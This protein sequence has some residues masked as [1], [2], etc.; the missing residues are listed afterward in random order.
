M[1]P[2]FVRF[3]KLQIRLLIPSRLLMVEPVER[4]LLF[5]LL[6][7]SGS[8]LLYAEDSYGHKM[9]IYD[10]SELVSFIL[11]VV[12]LLLAIPKSF[13]LSVPAFQQRTA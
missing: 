4:C 10:D 9:G 1:L 7:N 11:V 2:T 12:P 3:A 13:F 8:G 6:L 5:F